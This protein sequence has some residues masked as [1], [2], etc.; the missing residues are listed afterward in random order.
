[1][2]STR[3]RLVSADQGQTFIYGHQVVRFPE[4]KERDEFGTGPDGKGAQSSV[5]NLPPPHG[6][7]LSA[8]CSNR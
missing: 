7:H 3:A 8:G 2:M 4:I 1:M 6:H 5:S